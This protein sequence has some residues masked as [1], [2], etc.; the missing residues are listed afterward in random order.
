MASGD[1]QH[2]KKLSWKIFGAEKSPDADFVR[3]EAQPKVGGVKKTSRH[4]WTHGVTYFL[5]LHKYF[6]ENWHWRWSIFKF[7]G[8]W[9]IDMKNPLKVG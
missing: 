5:Q 7:V 8:C 4:L 3:K 2:Q 1:F 9:N 6:L